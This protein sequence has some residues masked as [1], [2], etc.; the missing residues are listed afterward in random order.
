VV[1][2][3]LDEE[4][5]DGNTTDGDGCSST[6]AVEVT[7]SCGDGVLDFDLGEECDDNNNTDGD[8]C[9]STCQLEVI[10]ET[11]GDGT[12]DA[13]EVCDDDNLLNYDT[14]NPTCNLIN[15]TSSW[16]GNQGVS[17]LLDGIGNAAEL[18]GYG[19]LASD[20]T[21][22][23][24]AD[25][26]NNVVRQINIAT[27]GVLSVAGDYPNGN[28]GDVDADGLAAR[29]AGLEAITTDGS[30]VWVSDGANRKI[31]SIM[32]I[33]PYTVTTV[34]GNGTQA[35]TD[36]I[37]SAAEFNDLRGLT[38]YNGYIYLLDGACALLRRYDPATHEVVTLAGQA[39]VTTGLDGYGTSGT[40]NSPRYMTSDNSGTLY[41][42]DTNGN[43]IRYYNTVT[44]WLGTFAGDGTSGYVDGIG[45][46]ARIHRPRGMTSDGTSIYFV[47]FNQHSV[48]QGVLGTLDV[49]TNCGAHCGGSS[50]CAGGY[51]EGQAGAAVFD[52]PFGIT[53]HFLSNT[54]FVLDGGNNLIRKIQ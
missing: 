45:T 10:G 47:E 52:G 23:W 50:P 41:I 37:G 20:N 33:P 21:Y 48:R 15:T 11:C 27:A 46:A 13:D 17:G 3:G 5:D 1:D 8:G 39:Y 35:C 28:S 4:C 32:T 43:K 29:F 31:K 7:S 9:S 25:G 12:T 30:T 2:Y 18:G 22:I 24:F 40:F 42:A 14:C 36:G 19:A 44:D 26:P 53:Y 6:C 54:L 49:S 51:V 38:Y 34:A 16:V